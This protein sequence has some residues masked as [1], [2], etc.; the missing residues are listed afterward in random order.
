MYTYNRTF[1]YLQQIVCQTHSTFGAGY[2]C[3]DGNSFLCI[4][5]GARPVFSALDLGAY[6]LNTRRT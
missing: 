1:V 6:M 4:P 3:A 5:S 2:W